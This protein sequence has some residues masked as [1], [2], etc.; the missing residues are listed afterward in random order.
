MG[1]SDIGTETSGA[2]AIACCTPVKDAGSTPTIMT[3]TPLTCTTLPI[4]LTS[5]PKR[6]RQNRSLITATGSAAASSSSGTIVRPSRAS[7]PS[8]R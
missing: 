8:T 5:P 3:A 2:S 4:T 1:S 7:T 6:V